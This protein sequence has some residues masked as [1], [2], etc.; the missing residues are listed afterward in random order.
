MGGTYKLLEITQNTLRDQV[1]FPTTAKTWLGDVMGLIR[2]TVDR[3]TRGVVYDY[4]LSKIHSFA[5]LWVTAVG[6]LAEVQP[7]CDRKD[8]VIN[9]P[10]NTVSFAEATM[11]SWT[12]EPPVRP[13]PPAESS[14]C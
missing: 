12:D 8:H 4:D 11:S 5:A 7:F 10:P 1:R 14:K 9:N 6:E 13:L 3:R 2:P